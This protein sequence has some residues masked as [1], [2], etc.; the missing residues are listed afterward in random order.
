MYGEG[1]WD[2]GLQVIKETVTSFGVN[3]NTLLLRDGSGMSHKNMIPANELSGLLYAIQKKSWFPAF[4]NSLPVAG[5]SDRLVGGTLRSRLTEEHVKGNVKAKTGTIGGVSTLS[6]Y[7][8]TK[9]G[10]KWIF[11]I[12]I[13]NY[14]S[15]SVKSIEDEIVKTLAEL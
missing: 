15:E 13:N 14:L 8:T 1:S 2:K 6:G 11:S 7:V 3:G 5:I 4:E 12:M 9:S 10:E